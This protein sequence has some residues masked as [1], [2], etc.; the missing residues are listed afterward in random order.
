MAEPKTNIALLWQGLQN[1][2]L[3]MVRLEWVH[4][5]GGPGVQAGGGLVAASGCKWW[6]N[7]PPMAVGGSALLLL[8][9]LLLLML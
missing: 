4:L 3:A 1:P 8:L 5:P 9:L 6:R 2:H 7:A